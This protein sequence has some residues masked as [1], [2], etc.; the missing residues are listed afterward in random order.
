MASEYS[1]IGDPYRLSEYTAQSALDKP[2]RPLRDPNKDVRGNTVLV[3]RGIPTQEE[4]DQA[5]EQ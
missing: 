2:A 3:P 1:Q 5:K 4:C